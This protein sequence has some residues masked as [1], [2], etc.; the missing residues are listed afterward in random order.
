M[1]EVHKVGKY[2][3]YK[4]KLLYIASSDPAETLAASWRN[5]NNRKY[6]ASNLLNMEIFL[7]FLIS[8]FGIKTRYLQ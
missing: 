3:P 7:I 5:T 1:A 8:V 6:A 2:Q 4:T